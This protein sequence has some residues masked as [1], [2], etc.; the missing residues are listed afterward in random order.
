MKSR[1]L[2]LCAAAAVAG[3]IACNGLGL[4][5]NV[6]ANV[7]FVATMNG[8][9]EVPANGSSGSGTFHG[10][11]DTLTNMFTYDITFTGLASGATAGHIHGPALAG[12]IAAPTIDFASLAG[13]TFSLGATNGSA[14]GST[15]LSA[16]NMITTTVSGDSLK[17]L[18]FAGL[19]YVNVHST[20]YASGEIRG[21]IVRQ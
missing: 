12:V 7:N 10:T 14:H 15:I 4:D 13:A 5:A 8:G 2:I 6:N 21:Q 3:T 17:K 1:A 9:N 18:L 20:T 16:G 19:T 11:L